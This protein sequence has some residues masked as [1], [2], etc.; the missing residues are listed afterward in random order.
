MCP[1]VQ[2]HLNYLILENLSSIIFPFKPQTDW[3]NNSIQG[4]WPTV[5]LDQFNELFLAKILVQLFF[6][7][8][9]SPPDCSLT[10]FKE[11]TN[12]V[13]QPSVLSAPPLLLLWM[14]HINVGVRQ[15]QVLLLW[16]SVCVLKQRP[17]V[18]TW[19][20]LFVFSWSCREKHNSVSRSSALVTL[21]SLSVYTMCACACTYYTTCIATHSFTTECTGYHTMLE[22]CW[23][24]HD[25]WIIVCVF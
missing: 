24:T 13:Q 6:N 1:W 3:Q 19:S 11:D 14:N 7:I 16:L 25:T 4:N 18:L 22:A 23:L 9:L 17:S 5:F 21:L 2:I 10:R 15:M 12:Q 20:F 8:L